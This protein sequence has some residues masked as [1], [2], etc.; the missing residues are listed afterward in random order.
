MC[1]FI[2]DKPHKKFTTLQSGFISLLSLL[3]IYFINSIAYLYGTF[4]INMQVIMCYV[5]VK[6][7]GVFHSILFDIPEQVYFA[8]YHILVPRCIII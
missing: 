2:I 8:L 6:F 4:C 1:I 7:H 3:I 5:D